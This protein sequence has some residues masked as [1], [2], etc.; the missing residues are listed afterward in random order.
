MSESQLPETKTNKIVNVSKDVVII[1]ASLVVAA[2]M[3]LADAKKAHAANR[4]PPVSTSSSLASSDSEK[5][6]VVA[7]KDAKLELTKEEITSV[8]P[9]QSEIG[10]PSAHPLLNKEEG[11]A[12]PIRKGR[13]KPKRESSTEPR[14]LKPGTNPHVVRLI[15]ERQKRKQPPEPEQESLP[16]KFVAGFQSVKEGIESKVDNILSKLQPSPA[17][18]EIKTSPSHPQVG[19]AA[20]EF[21]LSDTAI[22]LN[23]VQAKNDNQTRADRM[24]DPKK[25]TYT[26][27][28]DTKGPGNRGGGPNRS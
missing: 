5:R 24:K 20:L 8:Q 14:D 13:E 16:A 3:G 21:N 11:T 4:E 6:V 2:T 7:P 23:K 17:K 27:T 18:Q 28:A 1:G 10:S 12:S 25:N 9:L 26:A 15:T 19:R 22:G